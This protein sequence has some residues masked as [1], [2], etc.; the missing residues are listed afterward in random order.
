MHNLGV[1]TNVIQKGYNIHESHQNLQI[2]YQN[3]AIG[4][5]F[6]L[7]ELKFVELIIIEIFGLNGNF[8]E[9]PPYQ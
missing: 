3:Q 6:K 9:N 5:G 1:S 2:L 4:E 8:D 7:L